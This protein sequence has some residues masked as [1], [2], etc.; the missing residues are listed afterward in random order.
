MCFYHIAHAML[1]RYARVKKLAGADS[2]KCAEE[3]V[4]KAGGDASRFMRA[5]VRTRERFV[6]SAAE[7]KWRKKPGFARRSALNRGY[8]AVHAVI[9]RR[10][11]A[12]FEPRLA[13]I[14]GE[15]RRIVWA[16]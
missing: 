11:Q 15:L 9:C 1:T 13:E 7:R 5:F 4:R 16:L 12:P 14:R 10:A 8:A 2:E 6:C 3:E